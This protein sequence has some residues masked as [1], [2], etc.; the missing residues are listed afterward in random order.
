MIV[1]MS[2]DEHSPQESSHKPTSLPFAWCPAIAPLAE[3]HASTSVWSA[4]HG[5]VRCR[6]R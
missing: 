4:R 5:A 1:Q 6:R 3:R 2:V